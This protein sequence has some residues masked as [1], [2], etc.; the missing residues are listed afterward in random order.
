MLVV[1]ATEPK[2]L[3]SLGLLFRDAIDVE[4]VLS[5]FALVGGQEF[6]GGMD[7]EHEARD[8]ALMRQH[9]SYRSVLV[10]TEYVVLLLSFSK[11]THLY[12]FFST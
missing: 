9:V 4:V 6:Y 10:G 3:S 7:A 5:A 8:I 11:S 1:V 12:S 2:T